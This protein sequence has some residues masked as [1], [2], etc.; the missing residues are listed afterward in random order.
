MNKT[1]NISLAG[2][3]F[4]IDEMAFANLQQYTQALR[5]NLAPDEADEV[6]YD[7]ELR[8]AEILK[9]NLQQREVVEVNDIKL[10]ISQIGSPEQLQAFDEQKSAIPSD[11]GA[12]KVLFRDTQSRVLGGVCSGLAH[13]LAIDKV[14]VRLGMIL[15]LCS[16]GFTLLLYPILWIVMPEAKNQNDLL[17]MKGV[18]LNFDNIKGQRTGLETPETH[19]FSPNQPVAKA[20]ITWLRN[21]LGGGLILAA[22]LG[23]IL[24][25]M[26]VFWNDNAQGTVLD[27]LD[28]IMGNAIEKYIIMAS[29]ALF[30]ASV[31]GLLLIAGIKCIWGHVKF[32]YIKYVLLGVFGLS[33]IA[34]AVATAKAVRYANPGN[35]HSH[36]EEIQMGENLNEIIIED[37]PSQLPANFQAYWHDKYSDGKQV[38][39]ENSSDVEVVEENNLKQPYLVI[40]K[41]VYGNVP[42]D[43]IKLNL[44]IKAN[45]IL[46]PLHL[47]YAHAYR[48]QV[49]G[50]TYTLHVPKGC[51]VINKSRNLRHDDFELNIDEDDIEMPET[52]EV[53]EVPEVPDF[54]DNSTGSKNIRL[55]VDDNGISGNINGREINVDEKG[56]HISKKQAKNNVDKNDN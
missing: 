14:W 7:I 34:G 13:Y 51:K 35:S 19:F 12:K 52:P 56:V 33:I 9:T 50:V 17:K 8:M 47:Q 24:A 29:S 16:T 15:L 49:D 44:Q 40:S 5:S 53:P 20:P 11:Y 10:I 41:S 25:L 22:F 36:H 27:N 46:L 6:M 45:R 32:G 28:F 21:I 31:I 38:Y 39:Q 3:A 54:E 1:L 30:L 23:S 2:F 26:L 37:L 48:N 42:A 55:N 4:V 43:K 18:P